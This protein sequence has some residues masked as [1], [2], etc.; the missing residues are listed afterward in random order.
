MGGSR[1]PEGSAP[2]SLRTR[3]TIAASQG[4]FDKH[5]PIPEFGRGPCAPSTDRSR[6]PC[7]R[8][9]K[10]LYIGARS[11]AASFSISAR[12]KSGVKIVGSM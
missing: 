3:L 11:N 9:T 1:L 7:L 2:P 10:G 5:P 8:S 12:R 6:P 4:D